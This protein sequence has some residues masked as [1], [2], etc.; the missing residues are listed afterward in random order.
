MSS[1]YHHL[2]KSGTRILNQMRDTPKHMQQRFD[3]MHKISMPEF[4]RSDRASVK[5]EDAFKLESQWKYL[6][7]DRIVI[8]KGSK[9][10]NICVVKS[11]DKNTNGYILDDNGPT[12]AVP[13]PK[14]FW[15]AGQKSHILNVPVAVGQEEIK[16]VADIDDPVNPGQLKTVAVKDIVFRGTYYD[17]NYKKLMPYRQVSGLADMVIP[18]PKP[19]VVESIDDLG[20]DPDV[21]RE[22]TFWVS[23][24]MKNSIPNAALLTLRNPKSKYRRGTLTAKDIAKLIAPKMPL[25]PTKKA[26]LAEK[27]EFSE[28]EKPKL[29]SSD[30]DI[31][32]EKIYQHLSQ[33]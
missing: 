11:H 15:L 23:S 14:P 8:T 4:L 24:I 25:T 6:P 30:K 20:T 17:E 21:A 26:Y 10:G 19:E 29:T 28:K 7:G 2:S 13:V 18:W 12:K 5:D 16:L 27:K 9:R 33:Q 1:G 32:S 3:K 31:I 22:Q